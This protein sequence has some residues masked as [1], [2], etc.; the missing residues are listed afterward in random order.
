[1][2]HNT[3]LLFI[4]TPEL[5][6]DLKHYHNIQKRYFMYVSEFFDNYNILQVNLQN[7]KRV[8]VIIRI[9]ATVR[10]EKSQYN[11]Y[12]IHTVSPETFLRYIFALN[13][14]C[15]YYVISTS[16]WGFYIQEYCRLLPNNSMLISLSDYLSG[17]SDNS[18]FFK[19]CKN[20]SHNVDIPQILLYFFF[21]Y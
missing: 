11:Y 3:A 17:S 8:V 14:N 19:Y 18:L 21:K 12:K 5:E 13:I 10:T 16:C 20:L 7:Y 2:I 6:P 15:E 4:T 1:M 9:E